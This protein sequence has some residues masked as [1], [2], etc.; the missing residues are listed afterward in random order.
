MDKTALNAHLVTTGLK[1]G[2]YHLK[3]A[4]DQMRGKFLVRLPMKGMINLILLLV[5]LVF[6]GDEFLVVFLDRRGIGTE[7]VREGHG[8]GWSAGRVRVRSLQGESG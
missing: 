5:R 1:R 2:F 6:R 7:K 3:S 4:V 8:L